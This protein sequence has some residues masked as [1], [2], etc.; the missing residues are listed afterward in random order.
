ML[1]NTL[2]YFS[3]FAS[4]KAVSDF[5]PVRK[6]KDYGIARKKFLEVPDTNRI[7]DIT[8]LIVGTDVVAVAERIASISGI[9]MLFD[10]AEITTSIGSVDVKTDT[11]KTVITI[12]Q[13]VPA[14]YSQ[15]Q[16][17]LC[18]QK[19]LNI[20]SI[21]RKEVRHDIDT[22]VNVEWLTFPTTIYPF[23]AKG[24]GNSFGWS[25]EFLVK[26]IDII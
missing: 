23:A 2:L 4:K 26:G 10:Y 16:L 24:L 13:P 1:L 18:Q 12:A 8:D 22:D 25:M 19:C 21:M 17:T 6:E 7:D 15:A 14:E 9:Y 3:K 5:W 20:I 11:W